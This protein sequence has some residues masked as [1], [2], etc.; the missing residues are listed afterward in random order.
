MDTIEIE[1]DSLVAVPM[2]H[3][4]V[5]LALT[6]LQSMA[7]DLHLGGPIARATK[8]ELAARL[9]TEILARRVAE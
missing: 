2:R 4:L 9:A 3:Q 5:R 7:Y 1:V 6:E 8:H